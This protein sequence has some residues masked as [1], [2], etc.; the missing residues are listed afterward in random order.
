M[1][2]FSYSNPKDWAAAD[3]RSLAE[4][5]RGLI[6]QAD[7][8]LAGV[9]GEQASLRPA[10]GKWSAQQL[11]GHLIDSASNN[12]QRL[13]R[14]QLTAELVFPG[15]QQEE[16]VRTQCYDRMDWGDVKTLWLA[17]NRQFAHVIEQADRH[18]FGNVWLHE[19]ERLTLGYIL[20]DYMGHLRHHLRQ[21]P[22][23]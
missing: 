20:A 22:N 16:W 13:I 7:R 21:M 2:K 8:Q 10:P 18:T 11:L 17:L 1:P 23:A 12:L 6:A 14:L 19:G 5:L 4:E 15:Y 3:P 9:T